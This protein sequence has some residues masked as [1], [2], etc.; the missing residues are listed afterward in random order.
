MIGC[1][2]PAYNIII[3]STTVKAEI[4]GVC[5]LRYVE[6]LAFQL[7]EIPSM[8]ASSLTRF[9]RANRYLEVFNFRFDKF[10]PKLP[11][12]KHHRIFLLIQYVGVC[13]LVFF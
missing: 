2:N 12:I 7:L 3:I 8:C 10:V 13:V 6:K 4:Y 9:V 11:K 5:K 1:T